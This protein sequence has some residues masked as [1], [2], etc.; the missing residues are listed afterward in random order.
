MAPLLTVERRWRL[1]P[2]AACVRVD[3][4]LRRHQAICYRVADVHIAALDA[5]RR[6]RAPPPG[7][8]GSRETDE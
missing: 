4:I 5:S 1:T 6:S 7:A 8:A 2:L 3:Q